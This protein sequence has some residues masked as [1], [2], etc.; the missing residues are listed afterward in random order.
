MFNRMISF[1]STAWSWFRGL[2]DFKL[3][4]AAEGGPATF[5]KTRTVGNVI[6]RGGIALLLLLFVLWNAHF[7]WNVLWIR[8]YS[9][10]YP[11]SVLQHRAISTSDEQVKTESA[12]AET[13]TCS[14]SKIVDI[15]SQLIDFLVNRNAWV[16]SMPQFKLGFLAVASWDAT[17]FFDNKA[18]FQRGVLRALRRTAVE[19]A[20]I[21]GR[22]RGTSEVDESLQAARGLLQYDERTW[23]VNPFDAERP[24]G[25]VQPSPM[26]Y[27]RAISLYDKYNER[28]GRCDALFDARADNLQQFLDRITNDIGS[29]ADALAK[30]SQASRYD[31]P[32][33]S[34]VE[35]EGNNRGWFDTRADNFFM[36]ASGQMYAY[37]G[38]I[39]AARVDFEDVVQK[40]DLEDVWNRMEQHVAEAAALS[41]AIISNGREDGLFMPAHL[42]VMAANILRARANM[43]ELRDILKR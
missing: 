9:L 2:F 39:Q 11:R 34:F 36:A 38:L 22:T 32:T 8:D 43:T 6:W 25:P 40:R 15:Q 23:W 14:R 1:F 18:S 21:L 28:L 3:P 7:I 29:T 17:P 13:Q 20:D 5:R 24:L 30:R 16:P 4:E 41:P 12:S 26:I 35:A 37:Y 33:N 19:L 42:S 10:A 27:R 31:A